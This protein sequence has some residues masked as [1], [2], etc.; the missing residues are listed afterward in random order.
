MSDKIKNDELTPEEKHFI[1]KM[2][3]SDAALDGD[4]DLDAY[5]KTIPPDCFDKDGFYIPQNDSR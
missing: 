1:D 4:T 2:K 3:S 5:I